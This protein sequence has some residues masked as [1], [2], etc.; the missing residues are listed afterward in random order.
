MAELHYL[1]GEAE[2]ALGEVRECLKLDP[3][4]KDCFPFYKKVKK[5]AKFVVAANE[6][7]TEQSWDECIEAAN[8]VLKNEPSMDQVRF[9]AYDK[10]CHCQKE[11]GDSEASRAACTEAIKIRGDEARLYCDRADAHLAEDNYDE[12]VND[13]RRALEVDEDFGRA[14]EGMGTA[15]KRQKMASKRDYYKILGVRRN[16]NKKDI[17]K[18]Y[19]KLAQKWHPD[20]FMDE[21]EKKKAEKKFMDIAAAKEVLTD[22]GK[23]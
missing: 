12:A 9:H 8:K 17:M 7:Q 20:N 6:A 21:E 19:R 22:K 16:A 15:Q 10:L 13:F 11:A 2:E 4:H 18:A 23:I 1:L 14:K 5:V 3:D